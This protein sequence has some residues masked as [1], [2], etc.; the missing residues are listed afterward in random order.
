MQGV[1]QDDAVAS[2]SKKLHW[3]K[4][5]QADIFFSEVRGVRLRRNFFFAA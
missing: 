1:L 2:N 3:L 4:H 5:V